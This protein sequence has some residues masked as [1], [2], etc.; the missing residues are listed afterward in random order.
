[1]SDFFY[2]DDSA[3]EVSPLRLLTVPPARLQTMPD[4]GAIMEYLAQACSSGLARMKQTDTVSDNLSSGP[5]AYILCKFAR[6]MVK[7]VRYTIASSV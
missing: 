1:M 3:S 5:T 7:V 4:I 2:S 6:A